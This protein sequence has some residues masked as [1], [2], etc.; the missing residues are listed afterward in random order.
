MKVRLLPYRVM[1]FMF[2]PHG[3]G[4][5]QKRYTGISR[6][7]AICWADMFTDSDH[8]PR[9]LNLF[10]PLQIHRKTHVHGARCCSCPTLIKN[11]TRNSPPPVPVCCPWVAKRKV[12][13][14]RTGDP[15]LC[16]LNSHFEVSRVEHLYGF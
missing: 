9:V 7:P 8:A 1:T 2:R 14:I 12:H 13:R 11:S 15:G 10:L 4:H 3:R 5:H 6:I 16:C